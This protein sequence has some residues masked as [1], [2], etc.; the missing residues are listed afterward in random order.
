MNFKGWQYAGHKG[1]KMS[2]VIEMNTSSDKLFF[3]DS[4]HGI[5]R[6]DIVRYPDLFRMNKKMRSFFWEPEVIDMAGEKR[7]FDSMTES[8]KFVFTSNLKRQIL[9]DTVQGRAPMTIFAPHCTDPVVENAIST[10]SF[11]ETIHSESYTHIIRSIYPDPSAV[12]DGIPEISQIV[13][14]AKS[15]SMAYDRMSDTPNEENLFLAL[16]AANALESL[17][18]YVSFACTFSFA[19]RKKVEGSAKVVQL[20]ARDENQHVGLTQ[21][22]I[23]YQAQD[24][25]LFAQAAADN[26]AQAIQ[27]FREAAEQ[28]KEW[29]QY[30]FQNGPIIG[31]NENILNQYVDYLYEKRIYGMKLTKTNP[32]TDN[33]IPWINKWFSTEKTQ[34][35]LQETESAA[36]LSAS[37]VTNDLGDGDFGLK[38]FK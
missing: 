26:N 19:E 14:C 28:E 32:K 25:P 30:L 16:I 5:A 22:L 7:S 17:R 2:K 10:W 4:G 31:L 38:M 23:K 18:F 15:I 8:E 34:T 21:K 33:P 35:A 37:A 11:F 20:I 27:I 36:Y 13:D 6:Y 24:S 29:V 9:L 12:V 3:G 1:E